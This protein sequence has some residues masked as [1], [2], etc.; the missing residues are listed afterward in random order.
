MT[1][2]REI[3]FQKQGFGYCVSGFGLPEVDPADSEHKT[4]NLKRETRNSILQRSGSAI[5]AEVLMYNAG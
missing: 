4:R 2:R 5:A 3:A 1:V